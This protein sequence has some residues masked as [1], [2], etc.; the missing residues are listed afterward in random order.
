MVVLFE[1]NGSWGV[2]KEK[3]SLGKESCCGWDV[4]VVVVELSGLSQC[5]L[6]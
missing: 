1:A 5:G 4:L 2:V 6:N 3:L